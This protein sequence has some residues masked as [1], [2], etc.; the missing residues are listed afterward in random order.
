M[1]NKKILVLLK[2]Y[3]GELNPFD[4]SALECALEWGGNDVTVLSMCPESNYENLKNLTR[5]GVRAVMVTD[6]AYAGS[7]TLATSLVLA[8]AVKRYSPD[9][10]FCGRQS[11]DGDTAQVPPMLAKR[12]GFDFVPRVMDFDGESFI[13]RGGNRFELKDKTVVTF[14][15]IRTL[16]FAS[17]FS[18]PRTVEIIDNS[19]LNVSTSSCG[20]NGSPT[21]VVATYESTVGRRSCVYIL[22]KELQKTIEESVKKVRYENLEETGDKLSVV[23]YIGKVEEIVKRIAEKT[24]E[25][26]TENKTAEEIAREIEQLGIKNILVEDSE[27]LKKL[28]AELAVLLNAG[29]CADCISLKVK[30]NELI[31][32][33][34]ARGGN[35]TADIKCVSPISIATVRT[36]KKD[37]EDIIFS[38]GR[39]GISSLEKIKNLAKR[40]GAS[41]GCSRVVADSKILPYELQVGLTGKMVSPKVYVAFG[42][43]GAVQHTS[44]ISGA[45]TVIAVNKDKNARI[46]DYADYGIVAD[47]EEIL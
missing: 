4:G 27:G 10:I 17:I 14:E 13:D 32:T 28:S 41:L 42:V 19:V 35:V 29:L 1:K 43:S 16:R 22:P 44:A 20:L 36:V 38:V 31:M 5:L 7:D 21:R 6:K 46:F 39:G 23:H 9:V 34:P 37:G 25:I 47:I 15:K 12:L 3:K 40:T 24:V 26:K 8:E 18:K 33:R 11:V 2:F 45:N 30:E